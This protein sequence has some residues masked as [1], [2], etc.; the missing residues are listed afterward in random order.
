MI[1]LESTW[2]SAGQQ[3][4]F[5][6]LLTA[7]SF[8]GRIVPLPAEDR[9]ES[10]HVSMVA[11]LAD[12]GS[13]LADPHALLSS[14]TWGLVAATPTAV[15]R[16]AFILL[17]GRRP[18]D[19]T[20]QPQRGTLEEPEGGATLIIS[21]ESLG[22]GPLHL[23]ARGPG[24]ATEHTWSVAGLDPRWLVQRAAWIDYPRGVDVI[25]CDAQRIVA[26]PRTTILTWES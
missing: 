3:R 19:A 12:A 7:L 24:I 17:D 2:T 13:T 16:A 5:R 4:H 9:S 21:V 11:C 20:L 8:P 1:T 14:R 23:R 22:A 18:A 26:I 15:D 10:A 6:D 25:L